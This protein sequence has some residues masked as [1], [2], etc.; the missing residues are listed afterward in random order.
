MELQ[1]VIKNIKGRVFWSKK[2]VKINEPEKFVD[3]IIND[4]YQKGLIDI[5]FKG[6]KK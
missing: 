6:S 2:Q 3:L 4:L 1:D 5:E